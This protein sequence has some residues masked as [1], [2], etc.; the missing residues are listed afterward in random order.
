MNKVSIK[1]MYQADGTPV[2]DA[3]PV[4]L[5]NAEF[6]SLYAS[7][8]DSVLDSYFYYL[9]VQSG[10]VKKVEQPYWP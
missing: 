5:T 7:H 6:M 8:P 1:M 10:E 9:T 3:N 2:T 4:A